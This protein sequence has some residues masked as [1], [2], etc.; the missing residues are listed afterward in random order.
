VSK[1]FIANLLSVATASTVI[2]CRQLFLSTVSNISVRNFPTNGVEAGN[3]ELRI[4]SQVSG[5]N[6]NGTIK[7]IKSP[8]E[9]VKWKKT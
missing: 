5:K 9:Y 7:L 3:H 1:T 4:P 2:W 6:R 8:K